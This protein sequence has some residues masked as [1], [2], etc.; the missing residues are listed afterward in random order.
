MRTPLQ[1]GKSWAL[2][3]MYGVIA[4]LFKLPNSHYKQE[5]N[6]E[7][8]ER[9]EVTKQHIPEENKQGNKNLTDERI[10]TIGQLDAPA[11]REALSKIGSLHRRE[12]S[13]RVMNAFCKHPTLRGQVGH[14]GNSRAPSPGPLRAPSGAGSAPPRGTAALSGRYLYSSTLSASPW[15]TPRSV[16]PWATSPVKMRVQGRG[17]SR[18][19]MAYSVTRT[20]GS[21]NMSSSVGRPSSTGP[22]S[23][24]PRCW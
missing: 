18:T 8:I 16:W 2:N 23:G 11:A 6:P 20:T 12:P 24:R 19:P 5:T 17:P 1:L 13:T 9:A 14:H 15:R 21:R 4:T 7:I 3:G 22:T 10:G